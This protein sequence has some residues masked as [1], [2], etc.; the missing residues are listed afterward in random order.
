MLSFSY[1]FVLDG[2]IKGQSKT[3]AV[4]YITQFLVT[5]IFEV[6]IFP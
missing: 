4:T 5:Y 2:D 3:T 6:L 1:R